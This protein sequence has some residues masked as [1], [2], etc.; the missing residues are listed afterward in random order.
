MKDLVEV[1]PEV[2]N[3]AFI[4]PCV[5]DAGDRA[6]TVQL[7]DLLLDLCY[8]SVVES[9]MGVSLRVCVVDSTHILSCSIAPSTD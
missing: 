9:L 8:G 2:A 5:E 6:S 4:I 7:D 1:E 3:L